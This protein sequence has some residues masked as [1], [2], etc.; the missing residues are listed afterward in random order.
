MALSDTLYCLRCGA[1]VAVV[2]PWRGWRPAWL[3]WRVALVFALTLSPF[4]AADYC[5]ML[6]SLMVFLAAGG[7]LYGHARVRPACRRCRLELD[8]RGRRA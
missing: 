8:E 7:P 5:V 2:R 3:V 4:L 1:D 6:P